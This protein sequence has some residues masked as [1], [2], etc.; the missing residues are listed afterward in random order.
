MYDSKKHNA[1]RN[2]FVTTLATDQMAAKAEHANLSTRKFPEGAQHLARG[3]GRV[4]GQSL[5]R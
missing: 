1:W 2:D 3:R 4:L 5:A